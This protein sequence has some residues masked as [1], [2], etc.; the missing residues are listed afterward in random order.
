MTILQDACCNIHADEE[1]D[2]EVEEEEEEEE[3]VV[4]EEEEEE[5]EEEE[6]GRM[7]GRR[8]TVGRCLCSTTP[9]P[10]STSQGRSRANPAGPPAPPRRPDASGTSPR[11]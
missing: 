3:E 9:L 2:N 1:E 8:F 7:G 5:E 10:R 6:N 4:V 11:R